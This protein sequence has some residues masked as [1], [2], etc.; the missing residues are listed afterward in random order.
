MAGVMTPYIVRQGDYLTKLAFVKGFDADEVWN[1]PQNE[2]LKKL[3]PDPNILAPGDILRIPDKTKE[4]L[5]IEK[6][7]ENGYQ[8]TVPKV[9]VQL[10]FSKGGEPIAD[11]PYTI[12]GITADPPPQTDG[13]GKV[14]FDVPVTTREVTL[15]FCQLDVSYQV[16]IGDM[17]PLGEQSGARM[18]LAHLGYI[19]P[20]LDVVG[21]AVD[22]VIKSAVQS[23]QQNRGMAAT[24]DLDPETLDALRDT[25]GR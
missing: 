21:G 11:Q 18:R 14:S 10:Q 8:A 9:T 7:T 25:H 17:D 20:D 12:E 24:G 3:R 2:E 16:L 23:F 1:D 19:G 6:G 15:V 13:D 4:D 5:P 22:D